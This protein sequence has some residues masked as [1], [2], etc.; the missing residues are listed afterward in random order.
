LNRSRS[1]REVSGRIIE[2]HFEDGADVKKGQLL[3]TIDPRPFQVQLSQAQGQLARDQAQLQN[4]Q[5]RSGS[6]SIN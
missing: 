1:G 4:A 3:F 2:R 5:T 6:I